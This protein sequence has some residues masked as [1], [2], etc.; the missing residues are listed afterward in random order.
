MNAVRKDDDGQLKERVRC[1]LNETLK[2]L[3]SILK[4]ECGS[5]FFFDGKSKELVLDSFYNAA[6]LCLQGITQKVGEGILGKVVDSKKHQQGFP[7]H[8]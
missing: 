4:A 5:I 6:N 8:P 1:I 3:M 7:F 2:D